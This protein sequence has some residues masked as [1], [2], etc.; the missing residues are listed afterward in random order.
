VRYLIAALI[1][2]SCFSDYRKNGDAALP[3]RWMAPEVCIV[4]LDFNAADCFFQSLEKGVT[5][6]KSDV[7]SL[8]V[9]LWEIS[10]FGGSPYVR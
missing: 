8:G 2:H 6:V 3:V 4:A 1:F 10:T 7:W 5:S 9:V